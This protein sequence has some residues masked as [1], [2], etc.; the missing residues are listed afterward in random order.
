MRMALANDSHS[1]TP[2]LSS[3]LVFSFLHRDGLQ[4][5]AANFKI[6]AI[7]PLLAASNGHISTTQAVQHVTA[8]MLLCSFDVNIILSIVPNV[9]QY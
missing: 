2:V 9:V 1:A 4:P 3:L 5:Q 6:T 8:T 7:K